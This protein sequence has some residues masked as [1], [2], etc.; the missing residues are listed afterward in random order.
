[1]CTSEWHG[2][3][4]VL[5]HGEKKHPPH[6]VFTRSAPQ[7]HVN[8]QHS[9]YNNKDT[10]HDREQERVRSTCQGNDEEL[11]PQL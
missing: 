10:Y 3:K 1:M 2:D 4:G 6:S 5:I 8:M 7:T 9:Q 11:V